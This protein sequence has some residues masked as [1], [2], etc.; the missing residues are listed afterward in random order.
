MSE[1]ECGHAGDAAAWVLGMLS[2]EDAERYAE[3]LEVC[4]T[5]RDEVARLQEAADALAAALPRAMPSAEVRARLV[6]AVEAEARLFRAAE[7]GEQPTRAGTGRNRRRP[8]ALGGVA[9]AL[10]VAIGITVGV[11]TSRES[12]APA[13]TVAGSVTDEGGAPR[14]RAAVVIGKDNAE[15]VLNDLEAPPEGRI[16]QAW[17]V[18]RP[19]MPVP[20]GQLFSVPRSGATKINLPSVRGAER[21]IVTAEPPRGSRTPTQPPLVTV[22]LAR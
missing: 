3:H 19:S 18:R 20:T 10:L 22:K 21:V 17:V 12:D 7:D 2:P 11:L 15:L 4:A 5:C 16:Y 13:R 14:A 6:A 9:A 1:E 8:L